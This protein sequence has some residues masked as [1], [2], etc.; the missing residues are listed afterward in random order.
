MPRDKARRRVGR[1]VRRRVRR[2]IGRRDRTRGQRDEARERG[3]SQ[4]QAQRTVG[5]G[6]EQTKV[7]E[8]AGQERN[9][10]EQMGCIQRETE[11]QSPAETTSWKVDSRSEGHSSCSKRQG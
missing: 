4:G 11:S 1:G 7:Q 8:E 5:R 10:V 3:A 6:T 9:Q 2:G